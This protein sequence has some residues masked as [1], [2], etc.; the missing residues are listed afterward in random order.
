MQ[1]QIASHFLIYVRIL[2]ASALQIQIYLSLLAAHLVHLL[3]VLLAKFE[4]MS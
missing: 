2:E 3:E 4:R 1:H